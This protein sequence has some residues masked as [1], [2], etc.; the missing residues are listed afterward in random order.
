M[1]SEM[2]LVKKKHQKWV[3]L[4]LVLVAT[5]III[6]GV[7]LTDLGGMADWW[8]SLLP[9]ANPWKSGTESG[10]ADLPTISITGE[11]VE[12]YE[13]KTGVTCDTVRIFDANFNLLGTDASADA[14]TV[15]VAGVRQNQN[16]WVY[17]EDSTSYPHMFKARTPRP[18]PNPGTTTHALQPDGLI[19]T[20]VKLA[21]AYV[22]DY[23]MDGSTSLAASNYNFTASGATP[24]WSFLL[25][26]NE[27]SANTQDRV[28]GADYTEPTM[29][30]RHVAVLVLRSSVSG[31][32]VTSPEWQKVSDMTYDYWFLIVE[33]WGVDYRA[34]SSYSRTQFSIDVDLY[35][36]DSASDAAT[37]V[38]NWYD[39]MEEEEIQNINWGTSYDTG[40]ITI[41]D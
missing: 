33:P 31:N 30:K 18:G 3:I 2:G 4:V 21:T 41:Q 23:C 37:I 29:Q 1:T 11:C 25:K 8:L 38:Y 26:V 39:D 13:Q 24:T 40:T 20:P 19:P 27:L 36:T 22:D 16:V 9:S 6:G 7:A 10:E 12:M 32:I 28:W 17:V 15:T 34:D 5:P 14:S 35:L